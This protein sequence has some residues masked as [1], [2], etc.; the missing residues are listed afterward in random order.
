MRML[1]CN[2]TYHDRKSQDVGSK[3]KKSIKSTL[4]QRSLYPAHKNIKLQTNVRMI[5]IGF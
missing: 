5:S 2:T 3:G 1:D 4:R